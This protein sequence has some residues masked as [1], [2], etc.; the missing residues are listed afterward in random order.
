MN[1]VSEMPDI[2]SRWFKWPWFAAGLISSVALTILY[3]FVSGSM[4]YVESKATCTKLQ[5]KIAPDGKAK[6]IVYRE[7]AF[8]F[9]PREVVFVVPASRDFS[10]RGVMSKALAERNEPELACMV[11]GRT[12]VDVKWRDK[13]RLVVS[14]PLDRD[15]VSA[16][17][18][19]RVDKCG[20]DLDYE[21]FAR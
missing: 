8:W 12:D 2:S 13:G 21:H 11:W 19:S 20:V 14:Y 7:E 16:I 15:L 5:E 3:F 6:A 17:Q 1:E 4:S 18:T 10:P 9:E